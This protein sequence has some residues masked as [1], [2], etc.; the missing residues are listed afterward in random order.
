M[1][2]VRYYTYIL[3][4]IYLYKRDETELLLFFWSVVHDDDVC[5]SLSRAR[6]MSIWKKVSEMMY[7]YIFVCV[8]V[9]VGGAE[10][11]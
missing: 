4:Y 11:T 3:I 9:C 7:V 8:C 2:R 1:D 10:E 6:V 5:I